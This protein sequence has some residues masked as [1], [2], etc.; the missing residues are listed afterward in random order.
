MATSGE[1]ESDLNNLFGAEESGDAYYDGFGDG[2]QARNS[3]L[4]QV[5]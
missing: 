3:V 1:I 2:R 4:S 5:M